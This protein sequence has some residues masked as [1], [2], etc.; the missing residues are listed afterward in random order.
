[1]FLGGRGKIQCP[2]EILTEAYSS[3]EN[4]ARHGWREKVGGNARDEGGEE[5]NRR[6]SACFR[7]SPS[8]K[9]KPPCGGKN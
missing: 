8:E 9:K 3:G 4:S 6:V 2:P 5:G 1:M 7:N